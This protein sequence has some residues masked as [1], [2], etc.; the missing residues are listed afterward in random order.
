M[1]KSK[2]SKFISI[3]LNI[4]LIGGTICLFILPKLYDLFI[5]PDIP[6][7]NN[8]NISYQIAFYLCYII[9]LIIIYQL[10]KIFN[11]IYKNSPFEKIIEKTLKIIA[12]LFMLLSL[13]IFIKTIFIPTILSFAVIV[14]AFIAS[15]SFYVLSQIFKVAIEHK[16]ELDYT[17]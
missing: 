4:T 2:I 17:V 9:C 1:Q 12:I 13:I 10:I 14:V 15:L 6:T 8:H 16:N 7:F 3:L 11:H 5:T